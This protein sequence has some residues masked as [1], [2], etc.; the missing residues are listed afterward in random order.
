[1]LKICFKARNANSSFNSLMEGFHIK[2]TDKV[3]RL[4][5]RVQIGV[6]GQGRMHLMVTGTLTVFFIMDVHIL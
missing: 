5:H 4:Q 6:K 3:C 1:M 2:H